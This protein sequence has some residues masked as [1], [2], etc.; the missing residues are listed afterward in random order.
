MDI[1]LLVMK[2]H[3]NNSPAFN[4]KVECQIADRFDSNGR[5]MIGGSIPNEE[6]GYFIRVHI[7]FMYRLVTSTITYG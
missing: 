4:P 6:V 1:G 2:R 3:E 5:G 7:S